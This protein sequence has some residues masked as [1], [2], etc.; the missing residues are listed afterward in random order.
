MISIYLVEEHLIEFKFD[1]NDDTIIEMWEREAKH[2]V[3]RTDVSNPTIKGFLNSISD[4]HLN[5][6]TRR[7]KFY[8]ETLK[9]VV[10]ISRNKLQ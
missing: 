1:F 6:E 5:F 9:S 3:Y 8:G 10:F 4:C 7:I 2:L